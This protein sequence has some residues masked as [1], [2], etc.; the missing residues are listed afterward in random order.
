MVVKVIKIEKYECKEQ[1]DYVKR[2]GWNPRKF[3]HLIAPLKKSKENGKFME[4]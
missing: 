1:E 4:I 2:E 3:Q